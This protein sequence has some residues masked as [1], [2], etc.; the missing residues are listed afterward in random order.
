M[1]APQNPLLLFFFV[2]F[3]FHPKSSPPLGDGMLTRVEMPYS[4]TKNTPYPARVA[5]MVRTALSVLCF[6]FTGP[7][8]PRKLLQKTSV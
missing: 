6:E 7:M 2:F 3:L 8:N 1:L 5:V 4:T